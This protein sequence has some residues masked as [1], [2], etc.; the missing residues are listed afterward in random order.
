M[1]NK[2]L[3]IEDNADL[4]QILPMHLSDAGMDVEVAIDGRSG[5]ERASQGGIDL[6]ILDLILPEVGGIEICR[7]LRTASIYTPILIEERLIVPQ[8]VV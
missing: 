3:V 1:R 6:I 4:A 2:V 8:A 7:R 5:L